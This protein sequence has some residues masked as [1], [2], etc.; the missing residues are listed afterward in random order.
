MLQLR[1]VDARMKI[2]ITVFAVDK[3]EVVSERQSYLLFNRMIAH[4]IMKDYI[5][6]GSFARVKE[7]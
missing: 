4:H 6:S 2:P 7:E 5:S 1:C 3:I